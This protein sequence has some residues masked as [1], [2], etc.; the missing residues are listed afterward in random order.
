VILGQAF[1]ARPTLEVARDLLGKVLVHR[2]RTS[3]TAGLIV[4]VEAYIGEADPACHASCGLTRRNAPLYGPPGHAYVYVNYGLHHLV[5]AVT[6]PQGAPAAVL[7]RALE[8]IE[9]LD[10][11]RDRRGRLRWRAGKAPVADAA[12]CRGPGNLAAA[13]GIDSTLNE[14]PLYEGPLTIED[15]GYQPGRIVWGTRV[16]ITKGLEHP[17]RAHVEGHPS[18]SAR[19][20]S[21]LK[22]RA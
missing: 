19:R 11:M 8:P 9:G 20:P 4:E 22:P 6:E 17:W 21:S 3:S 7:V 16:G 12:L 1:Y 10:A 5:N 2:D 15:R 13:M 18:V 14:R